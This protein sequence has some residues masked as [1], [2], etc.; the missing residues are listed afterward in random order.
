MNPSNIKTGIVV[1]IPGNGTPSYTN[2]IVTIPSGDISPTY[3]NDIVNIPE[4]H[5]STYN[6]EIVN[7]PENVEG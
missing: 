3:H 2:T 6:N 7:I 1:G 4:G 5:D